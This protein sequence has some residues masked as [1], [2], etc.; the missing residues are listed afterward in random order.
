MTEN[1]SEERCWTVCGKENDYE[2]IDLL[3]EGAFGEV[4]LVKQKSTG[5]TFALKTIDKSFLQRQQKSHYVFQEK[6]LLKALGSRHTPRLLATFQSE[7]RLNFLLEHIPGGSLAQLL[8]RRTLTLGEIRYLAANIVLLL[9]HL[10]AH[11]VTHRD[12]KPENLLIDANG[13][14][15]LI[16]FGTADVTLLPG[17]NDDLFAEYAA[18]RRRAGRPMHTKELEDRTQGKSLVGTVYYVAPEMLDDRD[19]DFGC[20]L[21]ALGVLLYRLA[22]GTYLFDGPNDFLI[23]ESIKRCQ[24]TVPEHVHPELRVLIEALVRP[25]ASQRLGNQSPDA[26]A[27]LEE[28]KAHAFFKTVDFSRLVELPS[29]LNSEVPTKHQVT[30]RGRVK[31]RRLGFFYDIYELVLFEDGVLECFEPGKGIPREKLRLS[32]DAKVS[33]L[34]SSFRLSVGGRNLIYYTVD[35]PAQQWSAKLQEVISAI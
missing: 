28:L 2:R 5:L 26:F 15:K 31:R 32:R 9:E 23:F 22:T 3:G 11:G 24:Y 8:R 21:W 19:V 10:R 17:H 20:D 35:L 27:G 30:C 33:N 34:A 6:L 7:R 13:R 16:D 14:L 4:F 29:P 12:L 18:I 25:D 1:A